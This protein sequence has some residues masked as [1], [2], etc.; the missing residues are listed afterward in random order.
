MFFGVY[1]A[2]ITPFKNDKIDFDA[3]GKL[4]EGQYKNGI[5]GI[6]PCGTTGESPTLSYEE[7][8]AVIEFCIKTAKGK[9]KILAG[10]ASRG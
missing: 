3:L 5:D 10:S 4:I 6:V 1:T 7:H 9:M 8:E 2:L